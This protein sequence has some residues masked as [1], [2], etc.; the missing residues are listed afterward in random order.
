MKISI[1][2]ILSIFLVCILL[3]SCDSNPKDKIIKRPPNVILIYMDDMGYGDLSLNGH[4][5]IQTP[6]IDQLASDGQKW[7]NFY[8]ASS[9]CSPSRGALLTGRYPIRIGLGAEKKRVFF[10]ESIGGLPSSEITIAEMLKNNGYQTGI[11][12]KW[13]LGHLPEY[14]P[15]NQGFDYYYGIPYS[16]DMDA[17]N[18]SLKT[19]LGKPDINMWQVPLM[20]NEKIIEKPANQFTI[21]KRYTEKAIEFIDKNKDKPFFLYLPHSMVHTPLFASE[22]FQNTSPRGLFGDVMNEVD[23]S[24]GQII[25]KL[26]KLGLDK[27]TLVI[28][29]SDNG[30]WLMMQ[31]HGGSSGLLTDGKGTTWEGGMRVPGIFYM[32][33]TIQ[34]GTI[35]DIGATLDI[36]PTIAAFTNSKVPSDRIMDGYDLS[37][38]LKKKEVSPRNHFIYYRKQEIYA[39]RKGDYKAHYITETSYQK[40]NQKKI[41]ETPL[42]FNLNHDP[43]EKY[44]H[45]TEHPEILKELK[46]LV[47]NH[48]KN[49]VALPSEMDKYPEI[50]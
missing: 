12:G 20:E 24:V 28:F 29:S 11:V 8:T 4:P 35:T 39:V 41:L 1:K 32:P 43:S 23:W 5:T 22:T 36:L 16:N 13:H 31:E 19:L 3:N 45:A 48:K 47:E 6:N 14:L 34:P 17:I 15:M 30:P 2:P 46:G 27:N 9:V 18:W 44:N 21:T 10:P 49:V 7:S 40:D 33:G 25:N 37:P 42:L 50:K 26:E 38:V